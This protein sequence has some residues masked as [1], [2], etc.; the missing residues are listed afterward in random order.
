MSIKKTIISFTKITIKGESAIII[1]HF[2]F[3]QK[4]YFFHVL[5][6]IGQLLLQEKCP[7]NNIFLKKKRL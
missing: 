2:Y 7:F 4:N 6:S 3:N 5:L 1:S